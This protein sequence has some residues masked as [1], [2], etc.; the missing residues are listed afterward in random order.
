MKTV[1]ASTYLPSCSVTFEIDS[2]ETEFENYG[3][4][5]GSASIPGLA[6]IEDPEAEAALLAKVKKEIES[7]LLLNDFGMVTDLTA[8][9]EYVTFTVVK[10]VD[11]P[12]LSTFQFGAAVAMAGLVVYGVVRLFK[13]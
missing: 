3:I 2:N 5:R 12:S 7:Y 11:N 6:E 4:L 8:E 13:Q 1:L 9:N 10:R